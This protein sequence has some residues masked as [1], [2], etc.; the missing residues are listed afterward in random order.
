MKN[1]TAKEGNEEQ[2]EK[3]LTHNLIIVDESG[4]MSCIYNEA[5]IGMNETLQSIRTSSEKNPQLVTLI[6]FDTGHYNEIFSETPAE[7][8]RNLTEKDYRPNGCTPL[9]DAMG[10]A[11]TTLK[12]QVGEGER[13]IVT[14]ITDGME[15]ASTEYRAEDIKKMIEELENEEW[16]FAYIGANQDAVMEARKMG[17]QDAM[18]FDNTQQ[19]TRLM[20]NDWNECRE[21][22]ADLAPNVS[23]KS[24]RGRFFNR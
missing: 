18:N 21:A 4:S 8:T 16:I 5:L 13:V 7:K 6:T 24:R 23:F 14:V 3:V 12:R 17:I 20:F 22:M 19:G 11:I 1:W 15:N 10:R 9:Y 2:K